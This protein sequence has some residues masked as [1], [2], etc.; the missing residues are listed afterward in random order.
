MI[1]H[2]IE[3]IKENGS[4]RLSDNPFTF[5]ALRVVAFNVEGAGYERTYDNVEGVNGRF[6]N[7]S[8]EEYKKVEVHLRYEVDKIAYASH[9]KTGLQNLLSGHFYLR[10]LATPDNTIQFENVFASNSTQEFELEYVDGRQIY[11]GLTSQVSF[12]TTKTSG[13]IVLTFETVDLPYFESIGYS[14][15]LEQSPYME[16]WAVPDEIPFN[17]MSYRRKYTFTDVSY[18]DVYYN[19][20]VP[21]NQ[22]NQD[23]TV[24]ITLGDRV[25]KDDP[26]G[27]TFYTDKG[28]IAV[29]KGIELNAG[30]VIKF[31]GLH[32]YRNDIRIDS[33]N[34]TLE[35][36]VL[37]PGFNRFRCNQTV[38]KVVF[39][40]KIYF[41]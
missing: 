27:F 31:D 14:T 28:N 38:R 2:D 13:D 11:V 35:Q 39:K 26:Y 12:D 7:S 9:L 4:Y 25:K 10:E 5:D 17:E 20:D 30:D 3:I 36:P 1:A 37:V 16:K 40:H 19:G 24:F 21:I 41:R 23:S 29:I 8:T 18:G 33:Y 6:Y 15:D 34:E 22:F 32:T